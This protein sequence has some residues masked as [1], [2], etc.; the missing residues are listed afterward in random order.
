MALQRWEQ[1]LS[2]RFPAALARMLPGLG[3]DSIAV[4]RARLA[5]MGLPEE[6]ETLYRWRN[7]GLVG[8]FGGW[9]L[10]PVSDL[11][12]SRHLFLADLGEPPAWLQLF[13]DQCLGFVTLDAVAPGHADRS[14]WY[15]HTHDASVSRLFDSIEA[16]IDTCADAAEAGALADFHDGLRLHPHPGESLD[17][18]AWDPFRLSRCPGAFAYPDPPAG[19]KLCRFPEPDWPSDWLTSLGIGPGDSTPTGATHTIAELLSE[20]GSDPATGTIRGR[21]VGLAGGATGWTATVDDGTALLSV[22]GDPK[23]TVFGPRIRQE[24]EFDVLVTGADAPEYETD[25]EDPAVAAFMRRVLPS[26]APAVARAVRPVDPAGD[27]AG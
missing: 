11:V 26:A 4:L 6:V 12:A 7:G 15:G 14:V 10:R 16:L 8:L 19:T 2:E 24:F 17:G 18:V 21:V 5:P 3:H 9:A 23:V 1:V 20:A 27:R 13:D 25:R 22:T